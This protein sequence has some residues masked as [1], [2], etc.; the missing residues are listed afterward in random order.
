ML[1]WYEHVVRMGDS[2]W[3][4]RILTRWP[5]GRKIREIPAVKWEREW[6]KK[7]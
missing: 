1:R 6:K 7:R 2:K 4:K 5:E 3:P